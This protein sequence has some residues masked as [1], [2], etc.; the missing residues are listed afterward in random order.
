MPKNL[1]LVE[2]ANDAL[3]FK[4]IVAQM[5]Q[6]NT[7][8]TSTFLNAD[9][10]LVEYEKIGTAPNPEKPTALIAKFKVLR[11]DFY[12]GK[13]AK[14][15]I[16]FDMDTFNKEQRISMINLALKNAYP[17]AH[18][19]DIQDI[20]EFN[21]ILFEKGTSSELQ[22]KLACHF[23]NVGGA[24]ELEDLLR[25]IKNKDSH[26]ADCLY[27]SWAVCFE[28]KGKVLSDDATNK[29][30]TNKEMKKLWVDFYKRFDIIPKKGDRNEKN[31]NW[32][33]FLKD[34]PT[35][36]DLANDSVTELQELKHFLSLFNS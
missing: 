4:A 32:E 31:T 12:N 25:K 3:I 1:I 14:L 10:E 30:I 21:E 33:Q 13:Y 28:S 17:D 6:E 7:E 15:G 22:I 36:F 18:F 34:Y 11:N 23:I 20:N 19:S 29:N 27:E 26:F 8:V 35:A 16:I 2:D 24:G 9:S 5:K